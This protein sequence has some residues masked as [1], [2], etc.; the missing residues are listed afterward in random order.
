MDN[1]FKSFLDKID[2][3]EGEFYIASDITKLL[4]H[5]KIKNLNP[6][7]LIEYFLNRIGKTGTLLFQHLHGIF[8]REYDIR[9][10]KLKQ[11]L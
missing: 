1:N 10:D 9:S 4:L 11:A 6:N 5:S 7:E 8:V 2:I 3:N